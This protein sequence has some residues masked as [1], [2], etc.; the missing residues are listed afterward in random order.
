MSGCV[1]DLHSISDWVATHD[2]GFA[3][4]VG[5]LQILVTIDDWR[6]IPFSDEDQ[7]LLAFLS[8]GVVV[9]T[10]V[11]QDQVGQRSEESHVVKHFLLVFAVSKR[12]IDLVIELGKVLPEEFKTNFSV[13]LW[14][15][16]EDRVVESHEV[17]LVLLQISLRELEALAC[18][19]VSMQLLHQSQM[20]HLGLL[21]GLEV[22]INMLNLVDDVEVA[23]SELW[24]QVFNRPVEEDFKQH[25][26]NVCAH[27]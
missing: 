4:Q 8:D 15:H 2:G 14:F 26:V 11:F 7:Q 23:K 12:S 1:L 20:V 13:L 21:V 24:S 27:S 3:Y 10:K 16:F 9:V 6:H 22:I 19:Q 5:F 17:F 18:N 25:R